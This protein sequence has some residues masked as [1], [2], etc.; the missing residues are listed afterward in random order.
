MG[1]LPVRVRRRP[2]P[3]IG[4]TTDVPAR[5]PSSAYTQ[6]RLPEGAPKARIT[7]GSGSPSEK[8]WNLRRPVTMIGSRRTAH[9]LLRHPEVSKAHCVVVNTGRHVIASDLN[10]RTGTSASGQAMTLS[11]L[12]DGD[13]LRIGPVDVEVAIQAGEAAD[14]ADPGQMPLSAALRRRDGADQWELSRA[15][16]LVGRKQGCDVLL[17]HSDVSLA[18]AV[19]CHVDGEL[20]VF[21]LGSRTGT[22]L[23]GEQVHYAVVHANDV[24]RVGP[25]ELDVVSD[26]LTPRAEQADGELPAAEPEGGEVEPTHLPAALGSTEPTDISEPIEDETVPADWDGGNADDLVQPDAVADTS[27]INLQAGSGQNAEA[28]VSD[29]EQSLSAFQQNL[30]QSA[31]RLT[32][33]QARLEARAADLDRSEQE[34]AGR[35]GEL[36]ECEGKAAEQ[37]LALATRTLEVERATSELDQAREAQE[38]GRRALEE[39]EEGLSRREGE[40]GERESAVSDREAQIS[41]QEQSLTDQQEALQTAQ[42]ELAQKQADLAEEVDQARQRHAEQEQALAS[43]EEALKAKEEALEATST[44]VEGRRQ[45]VEAYAAEVETYANQ[46]EAEAAKFKAD[47]EAMAETRQQL[48]DRS[49]Q[50]EDRSAEL[51]E[52]EQEVEQQHDVL[53]GE[54]ARTESELAAVR[55]QAALI[56]KAQAALAQANAVFEGGLAPPAA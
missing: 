54:R 39:A 6:P 11:E 5:T 36:E 43:A 21:D 12:H 29:L 44:E 14:D 55:K 32:E 17:D 8:S 48:D 35:R 28:I 51:D 38:Q 10:S 1:S 45:E 46:I 53:A 18:H 23:N 7:I 30:T 40:L 3:Q 52:Q 49:Q 24:L 20:A 50:L 13:V 15:V 25:L 31:Q 34:L 27:A 47:A 42:A 33:W 56:Q 37:E 2:G 22:W 16:V 41:E 4:G 26:A 9:I 19:L